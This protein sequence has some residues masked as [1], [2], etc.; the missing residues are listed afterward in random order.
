MLLT[1]FSLLKGSWL[2]SLEKSEISELSDEYQSRFI[3]P[4]SLKAW[5]MKV[6]ARCC[7]LGSFVVLLDLSGNVKKYW[8][9]STVAPRS[10]V[11]RL[12]VD[13]QESNGEAN[14]L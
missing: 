6:S 12:L 5:W 7:T 9:S 14:W 2:T 3:A 11:G 4:C 8:G 10:D 13:S 1:M